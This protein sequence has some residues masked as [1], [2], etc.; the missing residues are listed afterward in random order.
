MPRILLV[1]DDADVRV[2]M[3]H[4]LI[5]GGYQ[6]DPAA[7]ASGARMLLTGIQY[8]LVVTDW[9]LP[10]G[11]GIEI[12]AEAGRQGI[13]AMI[14]TAYAFRFPERELARYTLLLKPVSPDELLGAV[15]KE[16]KQ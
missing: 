16:L 4:V 15:A 10:D 3:E 8:D 9:V 5:G 14:V 12:A 1:E 7:T 11:S 2:L 13:R 6:V